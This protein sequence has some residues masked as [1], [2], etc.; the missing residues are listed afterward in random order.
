MEI[1]T[2]FQVNPDYVYTW[3][4]D[5]ALTL[6]TVIHEYINTRSKKLEKVIED[7]IHA[8]AKLQTVL[9]PSGGL[10]SGAGL[11]E[12]KFQI[13]GTSFKGAWGRPQRDGPALRAIALLEYSGYLLRSRQTKKVRNVIWP[14]VSIA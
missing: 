10:Y 8:Q 1:L 11:G 4:R 5:S 9:N 2:S 7:Y 14:V 6:T 3:T 13:D 12:P